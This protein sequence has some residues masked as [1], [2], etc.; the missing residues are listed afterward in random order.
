M[1]RKMFCVSCRQKQWQPDVEWMEQYAGAVMYPTAINEKWTP[2]P[3]NGMHIV[4][5]LRL[6]AK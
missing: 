1:L 5:G 4:T 3:W 6:T 2:P